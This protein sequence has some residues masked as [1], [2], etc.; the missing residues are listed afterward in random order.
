MSLNCFF[1][2][3]FGTLSICICIWLIDSLLAISESY[4][5]RTR[6]YQHHS[7]K[8]QSI[9]YSSGP[10]CYRSLL[11]LISNYFLSHTCLLKELIREKIVGR[12][13]FVK[14]A[15]LLEI[16]IFQIVKTVDNQ[17]NNY[18]GMKS[19]SHVKWMLDTTNQYHRGCFFSCLNIWNLKNEHE[20]FNWY[21]ILY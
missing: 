14:L 16:I 13:L 19:C 5:E 15:V 7:I 8:K 18:T 11:T 20:I 3:C 10:C 12:K 2:V 17:N 4:V 21:I 6:S 9:K 1:Y